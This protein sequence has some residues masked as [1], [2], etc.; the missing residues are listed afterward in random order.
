MNASYRLLGHE[1]RILLPMTSP[2]K[3]TTTV[4]SGATASAATAPDRFEL[5]RA[6]ASVPVF[7]N[8]PSERSAFKTAIRAATMAAG[9]SDLIA[10]TELAGP[11]TQARKQC[12]YGALL[13][14]CSPT[15]QDVVTHRLTVQEGDGP[16]LV[17][18]LLKLCEPNSMGQ[19]AKQAHSISSH[20]R[21]A[22]PP[23]PRPSDTVSK[24]IADNGAMQEK[25]SPGLLMVYLLN[26]LPPCLQAFKAASQRDNPDDVDQ[27]LEDLYA[28]EDNFEWEEK[29]KGDGLFKKMTKTALQAVATA[30][31]LCDQDGHTAQDCP[32]MRFVISK[33]CENHKAYGHKTEECTGIKKGKGRGRGKG[34]R[35]G[36]KGA[37]AT[38]VEAEAAQSA[39]LYAGLMGSGSRAAMATITM[40]TDAPIAFKAPKYTVTDEELTAQHSLLDMPFVARSVSEL[41]VGEKQQLYIDILDG[42]ML[43]SFKSNKNE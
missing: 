41:S 35:Y 22:D 6:L 19:R 38:A 31:Q 28:A 13:S 17:K 34:G 26:V 39:M 10:G 43:D 36:G 20:P 21:M 37:A 32:Y 23:G 42:T 1:P 3:S 25:F 11:H 2:A 9:Y 14:R 33:W 5:L 27:F 8:R 7:S 40:A 18:A 24:M 12:L 15:L 4:T 29:P 30:C 16:E